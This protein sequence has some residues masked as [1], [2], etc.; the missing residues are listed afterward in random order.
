MYM[1]NSPCF[2][3]NN[4]HYYRVCGP[5]SVKNKK[6]RTL[7][8]NKKVNIHPNFII[9]ISLD[10]KKNSESISVFTFLQKLLIKILSNKIKMCLRN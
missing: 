2:K 6:K 3:K 4:F 5:N 10:R 9:F 7:N 1:R 8:S